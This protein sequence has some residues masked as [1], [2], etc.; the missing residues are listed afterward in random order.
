MPRFIFLT[1]ILFLVSC[2]FVQHEHPVEDKHISRTSLDWSGTYYGTLPCA[3]CPGIETEIRLFDFNGEANLGQYQRLSHYLGQSDD[4]FFKESGTFRWAQD[5]RSIELIKEG[6]VSN[7]WK[8][9][10]GALQMLDQKGESFESSMS[11]AYRLEKLMPKQRLAGEMQ[12]RTWVFTHISGQPIKAKHQAFIAFNIDEKR[13]T[14][15]TGCNRL[16][17]PIEVSD[18]QLRFG[19]LAMTRRAC[20]ESS[21]ESDITRI[22]HKTAYYRYQQYNLIIMDNEHNAIATLRL[23]MTE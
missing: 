1:S 18:Q 4:R 17:G 23:Q 13:V 12:P 21:I 22:L 14:G 3:D 8:V 16:A 6:Q 11:E 20:P 10:E 2:T 15:F 7:T 5:G 9:L 19:R